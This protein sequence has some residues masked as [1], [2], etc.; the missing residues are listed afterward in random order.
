MNNVYNSLPFNGSVRINAI[1]KAAI[2]NI[3][4][5]QLSEADKTAVA[6]SCVTLSGHLLN[7]FN[8]YEHHDTTLKHEYLVVMFCIRTDGF[9]NAFKNEVKMNKENQQV[10][11][12]TIDLWNPLITNLIR[13]AEATGNLSLIKSVKRLEARLDSY[14]TSIQ[15][16]N[17]YGKRSA[18]TKQL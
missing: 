16:E 10:V 17:Q 15:K 4:E 18:S 14:I 8:A 2:A 5:L 11:T 1:Y 12:A 13:S 9:L 7:I 3:A 6:N